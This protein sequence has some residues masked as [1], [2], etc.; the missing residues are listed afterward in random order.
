MAEV[1]C[2][3]HQPHPYHSY[4]FPTGY[5]FTPHRCTTPGCTTPPVIWLNPE[6]VKEYERGER[7]FQETDSLETLRADNRGME[8]H[9]DF[10]IM[11][12][13]ASWGRSL[14]HSLAHLPR[15]LVEARRQ[16]SGVL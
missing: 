10:A 8:R 4:A 11:K 13:L 16:R 2:L 14:W 15:C 6:E 9:R 5:P 1:K 7:R 12:I 3:Q